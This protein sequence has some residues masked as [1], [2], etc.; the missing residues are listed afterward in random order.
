MQQ[1]LRQQCDRD[2]LTM[3]GNPLLCRRT[4]RADY[5]KIVQ[6][7]QQYGLSGTAGQSTDAA[8]T[9]QYSGAMRIQLA[10]A[11][12]L[13]YHREYCCN[14]ST[15]I[16]IWHACSSQQQARHVRQCRPSLYGVTQYLT[17]ATNIMIIG[18]DC[19]ART[20]CKKHQGPLD[21]VKY[22][23]AVISPLILLH[24]ICNSTH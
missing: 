17:Y 1:Q 14:A 20:S 11:A 23:T 12:T 3:H 6:Q 16:C 2:A 9:K 7:Q 18:H 19:Q 5:Y 13:F 15:M 10:E 21:S 24:W 4:T 8:I 22:A